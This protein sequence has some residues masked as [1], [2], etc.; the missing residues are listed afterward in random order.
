M[1]E[2]R[3]QSLVWEQAQKKLSLRATPT[4]PVL[5][6]PGAA[7]TENMCHSYWA[8]AMEP[9]LCK[10]KKKTRGREKPLQWEASQLESS[11]CSLQIEKSR[12]SSKDPANPKK[13]K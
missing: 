13:N 9:M 2:T 10:K 4:E 8:S 5:Q 7:T 11:P 1:Q 6:S 12:S 3:V